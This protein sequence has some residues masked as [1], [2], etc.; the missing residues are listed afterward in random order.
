MRHNIIELTQVGDDGM[1]R[2]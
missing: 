2:D 1:Q